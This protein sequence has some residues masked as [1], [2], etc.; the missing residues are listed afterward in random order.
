M[1]AGVDFASG[2]F[3]F[4]FDRMIAGYD[5]ELIMNVYHR[6]ISGCDIVGASSD[7]KQ[8]TTSRIFYSLF[9]KNS[10]SQYKIQTESFRILSRRA[11]NRINQMSLT[12]PYRKAVYAN[13]G[14]RYDNIIYE[15]KVPALPA[16]P[17]K[18]TYRKSLAFD[19][20]IIFTNVAYKVSL[21]FTMLM[22]CLTIFFAVYTL[23][24]FLYSKPVEGWTTTMILLTVGFFGIFGV[25]SIVIK[26]LS[27]IV[28]LIFKK[29]KYVIG[30]IEKL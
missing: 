13:C 26:Y 12:I 3:V 25:L 7:T 19:S 30:S 5:N 4:E 6:C 22:M 23:V 9:N 14:L 16:P 20:I 27:V 17:V 10:K 24:I 29:T 8:S 21:A 2:D 18:S 11:I 15:E 28:N 1:I